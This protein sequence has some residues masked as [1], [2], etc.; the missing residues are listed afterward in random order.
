MVENTY[1]DALREPLGPARLSHP[2]EYN[3]ILE[4]AKSIGAEVEFRPG[5]LAY[6]MQFGKPGRLILDP[7]ASIGALR[8]EYTHMLDDLAEGYPGLRIIADSEKFWEFEFRGYLQEINLARKIKDS[9]AGRFILNE[10]RARR[11]EILGR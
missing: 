6:D 5:T 10:M 7:D 3:A 1:G 4:H 2:E 11:L 9:D 8:H